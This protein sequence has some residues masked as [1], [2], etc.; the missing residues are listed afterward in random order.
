MAL[1]NTLLSCVLFKINPNI[2]MP[3]RSVFLLHSFHLFISIHLMFMFVFNCDLMFYFYE[4]HFKHIFIYFCYIKLA[5]KRM[6]FHFCEIVF[7][8]QMERKEKKRPKKNIYWKLHQ[9]ISLFLFLCFLFQHFIVWIF[10][11]RERKKKFLSR[12]FCF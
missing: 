9:R 5:K 11:F 4:F 6:S 1:E 12:C 7:F 10:F 3:R 2:N 8:V